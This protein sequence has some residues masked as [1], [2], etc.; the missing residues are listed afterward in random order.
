MNKNDIDIINN[1][2]D[3]DKKI[4]NVYVKLSE[5]EENENFDLYNKYKLMLKILISSENNLFDSFG[6]SYERLSGLLEYI[7]SLT[8]PDF[9]SSPIYAICDYENAKYLSYYRMYEK[10]KM[11]LMNDNQFVSD[12]LDPDLK[13]FESNKDE[14]LG[15]IK[16]MNYNLAREYRRM[17]M[18]FLNEC[19]DLRVVKRK[20]LY[21]FVS[22][23]IEDEMLNN[24]FVIN[25]CSFWDNLRTDSKYNIF[26]NYI[27]SKTGLKNTKIDLENLLDFALIEDFNIL[28]DE[29]SECMIDFNSIVCSFKAG[30]L[31]LSDEDIIELK[32]WIVFFCNDI[33][34]EEDIESV[35]DLEKLENI[36]D[37]VENKIERLENIK[38]Y[39]EDI[40][41]NVNTYRMQANRDG[42]GKTYRLG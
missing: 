16:I 15:Y 18:L 4:Y 27:F 39:I 22:P 26:E 30:L 5:L 31:F 20:Y 35:E 23:L 17:N 8:A 3:I 21:S 25:N 9:A 19:D 38:D 34:G 11:I 42:K 7:G 36:D 33:L 29:F 28:D 6:N 41:D 13:I 24:D 40:L 10:I 1:I 2:F 37:D 14:S 12:N 32:K